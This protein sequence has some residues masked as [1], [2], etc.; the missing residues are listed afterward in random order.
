MAKWHQNLFVLNERVT[1]SNRG[2]Y[3][4]FSMVPVG[5]TNISSIK[6]NSDSVNIAPK[7]PS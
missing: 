4:L 5:A 2:R 6:V 1:L 7:T 3:G